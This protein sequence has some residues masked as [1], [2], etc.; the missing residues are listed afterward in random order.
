MP[1]MDRAART[2]HHVTL[3]YP[4]GGISGV[5]HGFAILAETPCFLGI[6]GGSDIVRQSEVEALRGM[7]AAG[8]ASSFIWKA[9][10]VHQTALIAEAPTRLRRWVLRHVI[11]KAKIET[12]RQVAAAGRADALSREAIKKHSLT[13]LAKSPVGL[14]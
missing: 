12:L 7:R 2:G 14:L 3:A 6:C 10:V 1:A 4:F 9:V 8:R 13:R 11:S 5:G